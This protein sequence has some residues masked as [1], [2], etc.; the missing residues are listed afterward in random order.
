VLQEQRVA[1]GERRTRVQQ[2]RRAGQ[3]VLLLATTIWLQ[4]HA[5][6]QDRTVIC[7]TSKGFR[8]RGVDMPMV[9]TITFDYAYDAN[10]IDLAN[11]WKGKVQSKS[12]VAKIKKDASAK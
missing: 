11:V 3:T 7:D 8:L 1:L 2:N 12:V 6:I 9:H 10:Q 4:P 5:S